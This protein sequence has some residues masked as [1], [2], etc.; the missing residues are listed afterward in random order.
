MGQP[1]MTLKAKFG[2]AATRRETIA[3]RPEHYRTLSGR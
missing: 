3:A 2:D 1:S